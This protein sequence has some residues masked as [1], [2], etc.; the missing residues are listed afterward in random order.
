M[1]QCAEIMLEEVQ[2]HTRGKTS[3][4]EIHFVLFDERGLNTFQKKFA[5]LTGKKK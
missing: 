2:G 3:L 4:E 1:D 5:E